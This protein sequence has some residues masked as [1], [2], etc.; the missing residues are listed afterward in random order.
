MSHFDFETEQMVLK[1]LF[2]QEMLKK[3]LLATNSYYSCYAHKEEHIK[4]YLKAVDEVF[5]SISSVLKDGHP[6]KYLE[7][8]VCQSGFKRLS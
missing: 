5:G 1:T 4:M 6:E 2:T 8:P 3:G 7:G